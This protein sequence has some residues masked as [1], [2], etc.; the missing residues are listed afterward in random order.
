MTP[1]L[2][3][4]VL[5][6]FAVAPPVLPNGKEPLVLEHDTL[7]VRDGAGLF[8]PATID[9]ARRRI[10]AVRSKRGI[11]LVIET[12]SELPDLSSDDLRKMR[13]RQ[14][15]DRLRKIAQD[16]ADAAGCNGL[17]VLIVSDPRHVTVVGWPGQRELDISSVKR[18]NLRKYLA[19]ELPT[20]PNRALLGACDH[21][22]EIGRS[23]QARPPTP[24][25]LL[26]ALVLIGSLV[27]VW[28]LL[29]FVRSRVI[30]PAPPIYQPAMLGSL[31]GV[32]SGYWIYDRLFHAEHP[33]TPPPSQ[34]PEPTP[35]APQPD[36]A[37]VGDVL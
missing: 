31:F 7:A 27:G 22:E 10:D 14:S 37:H 16:H 12:V 11:D 2:V 33:L 34:H 3:S 19:R 28:I 26:A 25:P 5:G 13:N 1:V 35:P 4:L 8:N 15:R 32:P 17:F 23:L 20:D 24:F 18:E 30:Y 9:K 36:P 21:F 29:R 6:L